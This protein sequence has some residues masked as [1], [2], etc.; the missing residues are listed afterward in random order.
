MVYRLVFIKEYSSINVKIIDKRIT[1][2]TFFEGETRRD[3]VE[4]SKIVV[5]A[6]CE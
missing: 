6:G 4:H 5:N 2:I 1:E 3:A